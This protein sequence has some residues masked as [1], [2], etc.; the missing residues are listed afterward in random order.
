MTGMKKGR[1]VMDM[2][3]DLIIECIIDIITDNGVD[4]MTG[5]DR[6]KK[7]VKRCEDRSCCRVA[8]DICGDSGL[9]AVLRYQ[10]VGRRR[11]HNGHTSYAP[12][13]RVHHIH[14]SK[15]YHV[16]SQKQVIEKRP[17]LISALPRHSR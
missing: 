13:S 11:Y 16:I 10:P 4:V 6:T 15:T 3:F 1:T 17:E 9:A 2:I 14:G 8:A 12:G 7:P 5:S